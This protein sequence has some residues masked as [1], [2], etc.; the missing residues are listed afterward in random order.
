MLIECGVSNF[1]S[2]R[3]E[4]RL[5]M[6]AGT[7]KE[8]RDSHLVDT[9]ANGR[10]PSNPLVRTAVVYGAN[11]AGKTNL[12]A[13]LGTMKR[14][15]T[16]PSQPGDPL[17]IEPFKFDPEKAQ[18]NTTFEVLCVVGGVRYQ[19]GFTAN[20]ERVCQEWLFAWPRGRVQRWVERDDQDWKLSDRLGSDKRVWQR[21]TRPNALFLSTAASLNSQQLKPLF[22][23]F[24][25]KLHV[26]GSGPTQ[27]PMGAL[28]RHKDEVIGFLQAADMAIS[29]FRIVEHEINPKS[30]PSDMPAAL[31][32][33][34]ENDGNVQ[35]VSIFMSHN[36]GLGTTEIEIFDESAGTQKIFD[37]SVPLLQSLRKG[38]VVVIDELNN[39]LHSALVRF[40]LDRFHNP[41]FNTGGA[42]LVFSTHDTSILSQEIF[43]RDQIWFCERDEQLATHLYPLSD[44]RPRKGVENL[45]RSYLAGRYG[46][47]PFIRSIPF[48]PEP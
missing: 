3:D 9:R 5:S 27:I 31:K 40:I 8:H 2:I 1:K 7:G 30:L 38:F 45:E 18:G 4:A 23:W 37:L 43:R 39:S 32:G 11:A 28:N 35:E 44:F 22:D 48:E 33:I 20:S 13:A 47:V 41:R 36:T 25:H 29:D 15:V 34:F 46:A 10:I 14:I 17:P 16:V 21:A 19:Y 26:G 12:L 6:V 42:Q 24:R